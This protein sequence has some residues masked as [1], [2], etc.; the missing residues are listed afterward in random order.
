[1]T[2]NEI[3]LKANMVIAGYPAKFYDGLPIPVTDRDKSNTM[4]NKDVT[5]EFFVS[6]IKFCPK[7]SNFARDRGMMTGCYIIS[8]AK[9]SEDYCLENNSEERYMIME[10][11]VAMV[12]FK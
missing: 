9:D 5:E 6:E 12:L 2:I 3:I 11:A 7:N 4:G 1:M 10:D 8:L